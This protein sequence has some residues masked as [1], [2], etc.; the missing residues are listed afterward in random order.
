MVTD[1]SVRDTDELL[2]YGFP[3]F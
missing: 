3:T 1:G 2:N